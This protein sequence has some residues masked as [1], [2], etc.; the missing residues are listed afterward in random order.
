MSART[1]A[2]R[3]SARAA[4]RAVTKISE[5]SLMRG[6]ATRI[7][8]ATALL[9][10]A[11]AQASDTPFVPVTDAM[12]QHPDPSD[13]LSWRRTL[14]SWGYSPLDQITKANVNQLRMV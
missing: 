3:E 1:I 13:W 4:T 7:I 6:I 8:A 12:I 5:G 10:T 11:M 14:D 9:C 2:S